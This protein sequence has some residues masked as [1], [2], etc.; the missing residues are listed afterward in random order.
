[1]TDED[2]SNRSIEFHD[3]VSKLM[4]RNMSL[5]AFQTIWGGTKMGAM[6]RMSPVAMGLLHCHIS[7]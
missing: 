5:E 1:M 4:L 2:T 6:P 3:A 7:L